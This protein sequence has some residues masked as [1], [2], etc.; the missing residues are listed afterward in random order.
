VI[1]LG[2]KIDVDTDTPLAAQTS[3]VAPIGSFS[4]TIDG[5]SAAGNCIANAEA[6]AD[7]ETITMTLKDASG[8]CLD[9]S[10]EIAAGSSGNSATQTSDCSSPAVPLPCINEDQVITVNS[11][12]SGLKTLEIIGH[13]A[14]SIQCYD[15]VSNFIVPGAMLV[16]EL[17][18]QPLT[19]EDSAA[20]NPNF[21]I[22][23]AG[24]RCWLARGGIIDA[25]L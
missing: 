24:P 9:A 3:E 17:G 10:F 19:L 13:K 11:L 2:V 16:A 21:N 15:R 14:G 5:R 22:I 18:A 8:T 1:L 25:A 7:I 23:D 20:C 4:F 6:G 12:G